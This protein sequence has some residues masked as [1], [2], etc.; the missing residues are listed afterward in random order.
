MWATVIVFVSINVTS[1][2]LAIGQERRFTLAVTAGAGSNLALNLILI[3]AFGATGAAASTVVAELVVLAVNA[4]RVRKV[5]GREP[6]D[7]RRIA[8]ALAASALMALALAL[9]P[10]GTSVWLSL[11]FGGAVYAGAAVAFGAVRRSDAA[12]LRREA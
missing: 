2:A 8:G 4:A 9:L 5:L 3:P 12:F 1:V 6:L 11:T 10:S 7:A